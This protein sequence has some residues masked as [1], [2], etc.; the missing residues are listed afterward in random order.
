MQN[1]LVTGGTVF[2]SRYVAEYF[3]KSEKYN[4]FVLNRGS[5]SQCENVTL[6]RADRRCPGEA[7][8]GYHFDAV[9]DVTAYTADDVHPLLD[10]LG[11]FDQYIM[12]SS[13]AVYPDSGAQPFT[14]ESK[15]GE[16]KYWG[17]Y[18]IGKIAAE[19]ALQSR[20]PGAYVLRPPYLYGRYNNVYR[21]AF[22]FD[23]AMGDRP[24]YL[25]GDGGMRLQFYHVRD[26]CRFIDVILAQQ[27]A[28]RVFNVGDEAPVTIREWVTL[29][30]RAVGKTPRFVC[31]DTAVPQRSYFSFLPYEYCLDVSRQHVYL[32]DTLDLGEG[33]RDAYTWYR[34]HRGAVNTK[35][36]IDYIRRN[37]EHA[38]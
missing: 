23:C 29:C 5:R 32:S 38:T 17:A 18:G 22:V 15:T 12:I 20:V 13:S 33:L 1:I 21:E 7:L 2:V 8:R 31:V 36:Y 37:L 27:P 9:I 6:I 30:Y 26:L 4:V 34:G 35:P 14:E 24:F 28:Q 25:P 3:S 11:S 10:A 19:Q 16:N